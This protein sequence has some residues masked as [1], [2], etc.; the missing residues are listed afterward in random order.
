[1]Q[2]LRTVI[3]KPNT[4]TEGSYF[5]TR[6]RLPFFYADRQKG[7]TMTK[8]KMPQTIEECNA[9]ME[10]TQQKI[11]QYENR[12]KM[13]DRK[14]AIEKHK[15]RNHRLCLQGGMRGGG[16]IGRVGVISSTHS[17]RG[18]TSVFYFAAQTIRYFNPST[19]CGVGPKI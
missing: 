14:S 5:Q 10:Y 15:E 18:G 1:M 6:K 12:G 16:G 8:K 11:R 7:V 3:K 9:E 19:P 2:K 4:S 13:L 17:L